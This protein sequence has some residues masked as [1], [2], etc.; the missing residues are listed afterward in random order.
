MINTLLDFREIIK[1]LE[2]YN[3]Y[4]KDN[5]FVGR[6]QGQ[7]CFVK[8]FTDVDTENI[9]E[10]KDNLEQAEFIAELFKRN[11]INVINAIP[12]NNEFIC[13]DGETLFAVY[14]WCDGNKYEKSS[15]DNS[16]CELIG[17]AIG[18]THA[19]RLRDERI[20]HRKKLQ[21]IEISELDLLNDNSEMNSTIEVG[22]KK[23]IEYKDQLLALSKSYEAIIK[24]DRNILCHRDTCVGN[25]I[26]YKNQVYFLDWE[27]AGYEYPE[28]ELFDT[29]LEWS[30]FGDKTDWEKYKS[31]VRGYYKVVSNN[32]KVLY[33]DI[34]NAMIYMI[35]RSIYEIVLDVKYKNKTLKTS[36]FLSYIY[37]VDELM[38][39]KKL[40]IENL[41][42]QKE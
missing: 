14:P 10:M 34:L 2:K 27:R 26:F 22:V 31:V 16:V 4:G 6:I 24:D 8:A 35:L 13:R 9:S 23:I 7:K 5:L 33:E 29:C 40:Y 38:T 17:E 30:G 19:L 3:L 28:F 12:Y 11:G 42:N 37:Q 20:K 25:F 36:G 21:K 15:I 18:K 32:D 39:N 41:K 1:K